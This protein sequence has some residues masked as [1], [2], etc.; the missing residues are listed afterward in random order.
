VTRARESGVSDA[1]IAMLIG[2]K[3]GPSIIAH[4]YGDVLPD[5]LR[6]RAQGI[7]LRPEPNEI[8]TKSP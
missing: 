7:R 8:D 5:R 1:E 3:T 6:R 2:D 4:T